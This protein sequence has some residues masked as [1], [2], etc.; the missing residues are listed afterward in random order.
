MEITLAKRITVRMDDQVYDA[1]LSR[2]GSTHKISQSMNSL[3]RR[4]LELPDTAQQTARTDAIA[5]LAEL[6]KEITRLRAVI[7]E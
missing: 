5:R 7:E 4:A 6:E 1:L 2:A 3:L